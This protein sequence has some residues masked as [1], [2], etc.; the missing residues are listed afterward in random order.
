[1]DKMNSEMP[2]VN[3]YLKDEQFA[4]STEY[5]R[6]M[7]AMP[8]VIKIPK[9]PEYIRGVIN[10]RGQTIPIMDL[11]MKLGMTS[12]VHE[13]DELIKLMHEREADH[14]NW[15]AELEKSV[16]EKREFKLTTDPNK[17]KFGKWYNQFKTENRILESLLKRFDKPHQRIHAIA[18]DVGKFVKNG[19]FSAAFDIINRTRNN[20][21]AEMI[22]LF[23]EV[24]KLLEESTREI[25]IV[26]EWGGADMVI[27]VDSVE[28]VEKLN[29]KNIEKVSEVVG[30]VNNEFIAGIGKSDKDDKMVQLIDVEKLIA[31]E[32]N[33]NLP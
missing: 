23:A 5:V 16:K 17:C 26:L 9:T 6:E 27:S 28:T 8:Q 24:R 33:L 1:M 14:K 15:I 7:V 18:I 10:L 3:F 12:L 11:R 4:V 25:A 20:E 19:K 22:K 13:T 2:W 31:K 21:L 30:T 29:Q 32:T